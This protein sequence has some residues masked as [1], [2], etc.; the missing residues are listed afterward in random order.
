MRYF[1]AKNLLL[2]AVIF[3]SGLCQ[4]LEPRSDDDTT[5]EVAKVPT[6]LDI[7]HV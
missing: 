1:V 3:V 5:T 4:D 6:T 7:T 2:I